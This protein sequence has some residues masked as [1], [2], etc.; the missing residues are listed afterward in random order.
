MIACQKFVLGSWVTIS[1]HTFIADAVT[2]MGIADNGLI[3]TLTPFQVADESGSP[4]YVQQAALSAPV[5]TA[6][7]LP[8]QFLRD[9]RLFIIFP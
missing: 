5:V 2:Q 1:L 4:V 3:G 9:K 6:P 7:P 8:N